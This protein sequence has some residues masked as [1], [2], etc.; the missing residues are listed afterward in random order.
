MS[1]GEPDLRVRDADTVS[2]TGPIGAGQLDSDMTKRADEM[3]AKIVKRPPREEFLEKLESK[4]QKLITK[5]KKRADAGRER[6][7]ASVPCPVCG[8]PSR[9]LSTRRSGEPRWEHKLNVLWPGQV[10]Q[11]YR[12]RHCKDKSCS[13]VFD[14]IEKAILKKKYLKKGEK[15][16]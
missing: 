13:I 7:G 10:G 2:G 6:G 16:K 12:F 3:N 11:I 14:S 15:K 9:V 1:G 5:Q 4:R 8:G